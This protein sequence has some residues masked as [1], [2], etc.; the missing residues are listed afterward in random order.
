[1]SFY[2]MWNVL[3]IC[4]VVYLILS[5][6]ER[7]WARVLKWLLKKSLKEFTEY[8]RLIA[9]Q[10]YFNNLHAPFWCLAESHLTYA[11]LSVEIT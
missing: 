8:F 1:M 7:I 11:A 9:C 3:N 10:W 6:V 2:N 4:E 5:L